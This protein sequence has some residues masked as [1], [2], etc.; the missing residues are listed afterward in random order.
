MTPTDANH[1]RRRRR[2]LFATHGT[3]RG[4]G[5]EQGLVEM[6]AALE[7][8]DIEPVVILPGSGG[9]SEEVDG[10]G[11]RWRTAPSARWTPFD[12]TTFDRRLW[13]PRLA[14][15]DRAPASGV[16]LAVARRGPRRRGHQHRSH[17]GPRAGLPPA[18]DSPHLVGARVRHPR[19]RAPVRVRR[20]VQSTRDR[21]DLECS[22]GELERGARSL[23]AA[24]QAGEGGRRVRRRTAGARWARSI[25]R[26]G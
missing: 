11:V 20:A 10:V 19:P 14:F 16:G 25:P 8:S 1:M 4:G 24:D 6:V 13:R 26:V 12:V 3:D 18:R 22:D 15:G 23:L 5:A 9:L 7:Y 2:V 21:L 17:T